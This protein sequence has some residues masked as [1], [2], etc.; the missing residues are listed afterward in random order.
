MNQEVKYLSIL[1]ANNE[2]V[3]ARI[4]SFYSQ[5]GFNIDSLTV[6]ATDDPTVSRLTVASRGDERTFR[7]ILLQTSKLYEVY[8]VFE[9]KPENSIL[10]EL[11]LIKVQADEHNRGSL[12]DIAE[13]YKAK[14]VDLSKD[15]MVFELTGSTDKLNAF[16]DMLKY[17][18]IIEMCRTGVTAM[19]RGT[20]TK[21][22]VKEEDTLQFKSA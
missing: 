18:H 13:I 6:S 5:R 20:M 9:L 10:K 16:L 4:A 22:A 17:Y 2:G 12:R 7:Q 8:D 19:E 3:L 14:V 21:A 15:S 1:V 11:L